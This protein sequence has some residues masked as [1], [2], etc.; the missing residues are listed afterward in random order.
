[1]VGQVCD[2]NVTVLGNLYNNFIRVGRVKRQLRKCY[3][4]E[5]IALQERWIRYN[6]LGT[7]IILLKSKL[8]KDTSHDLLQTHLQ[9]LFC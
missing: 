6:P 2:K 4:A 5:A 9:E 8:K 1:M 3:I 7:P